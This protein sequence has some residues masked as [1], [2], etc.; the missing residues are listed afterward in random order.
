M[1]FGDIPRLSYN[2]SVVG[3]RVFAE[4]SNSSSRQIRS[5]RLLEIVRKPA[6]E[7]VATRAFSNTFTHFFT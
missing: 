7:E 3:D 6:Q 2:V 1:K 4:P 5:P